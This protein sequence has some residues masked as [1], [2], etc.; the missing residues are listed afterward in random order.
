[1]KILVLNWLDLENP[2]SG[3]AEVHLR[4]IFRRLVEW[5]HSVTLLCSAWPGCER[6][7]TLDG[8]EVH[9]VG[10]RHTLSFAAPLYFRRRLRDER[11]DVVVEDLNK[12][13]FFSPFGGS[14][15]RWP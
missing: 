9:R 13:P 11:F 8:I 5:G 3:G 1:M 12:V 15:H 7:A 6:R 2:H 10:N 14:E 4:E